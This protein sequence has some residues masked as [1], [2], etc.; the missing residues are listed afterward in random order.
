MEQKQTCLEVILKV[1]GKAK[2][3]AFALQKWLPVY[4][5]RD[6]QRHVKKSKNKKVTENGHR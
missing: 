2:S 5:V 6:K 3:S 4:S 1:N